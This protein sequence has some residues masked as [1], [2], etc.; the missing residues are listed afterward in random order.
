[1][2][3]DRQLEQEAMIQASVRSINCGT[4]KVPT[5]RPS[6]VQTGLVPSRGL[7]GAIQWTADSDPWTPGRK[8]LCRQ[9]IKPSADGN[10]PCCDVGGSLPIYQAWDWHVGCWI[11]A[12]LP[13]IYR[14]HGNL[15]G[16]SPN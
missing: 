11:M 5:K 12:G 7:G 8:I 10:V 6:G 1:M 9:L 3:V 14:C 4:A 2:V 13:A 15:S 16:C